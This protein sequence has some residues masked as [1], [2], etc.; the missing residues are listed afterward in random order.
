MSQSSAAASAH[1]P[2]VADLNIEVSRRYADALIGSAEHE[3]GVERAL[4]ELSEIQR[5]VLGPFPRFAAI[6]DSP[7][8]PAREK[9]RMLV[10]ILQDRASGLALK[11]LR[12]LNRN[13]RLE[14]F[15]TILREARS[16]WDKR[17]GRV[18]VRVRSAVSL[19]DDQ[20][21]SLRS[22]LARLLAATP[23][24]H[25]VTDPRLIGGLVIE[26][27]DHRY[28]ASV[29]SRLEQIRQRLSEG[30]THE[31]QSRRDQF[32]HST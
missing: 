26:V 18:H 21:E 19:V 14:L 1:E 17:Q 3:G 12:V 32:S 4:E 29:K 31:I 16:I 6:L 7:R 28:D 22:R 23:I 30:K 13:G 24:L 20:L 8:V 15:D 27:G 11:F 2:V 25:V 5:D 9:D 10:E